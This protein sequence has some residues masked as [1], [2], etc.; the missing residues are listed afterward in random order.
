MSWPTARL[1]ECIESASSGFA[2]GAIDPEGVAQIRMNNVELDGRLNFEKI[3]YV[4]KS[5]MKIEKFLLA[6]DD[7]LFNATNSPNLVGKSAL[8]RG[9]P[10]PFVY[11]NHFIRIRTNRSKLEPGFLARWLTAQQ[12]VGRFELM[13][14]KWV[15]QASVRREDLLNLALPLPPL[16]EQ[17]RISAIL[18]KADALRAKR[19]EAI[20]KQDQL[21][22]SLFLEMFGDPVTNPKGWPIVALS[23]YG[24]VATG[25]TPPR[26]NAENYG[27]GIEW[28]KSDN[29]NTPH[30]YV[31][32]ADEQLSDMGERT[33][34]VVSS[35]SVLVTC[36]AGSLSC[37]GNL[38]IT[39][40]RVAF[41]QQINAIT[42]HS[43]PSEFLYF[44]LKT[45]KPL[46]QGASTNGMKGMVNKSKFCAIQVPIP[47]I[48]LQKEFSRNFLEMHKLRSLADAALAKQETLLAGLQQRAFEGN[49]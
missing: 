22:Q 33:A 1:S 36:I 23:S 40:R 43:A 25:N 34:R 8:I 11:S 35:G 17:R 9:L 2:S 21:L 31:T 6:E 27:T 24:I 48:E 41:N 28:I 32:K 37:I 4:P 12:Q 20:V 18:D 42:P 7:V 15:N 30:D 3:R 16:P 13:C 46:I 47:P 38:A 29:L 26:S 10:E 14:N 49:L 19:S 39:D 45:A 5:T 44:L